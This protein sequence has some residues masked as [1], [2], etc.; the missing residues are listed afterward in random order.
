MHFAVHAVT[1][2][3]MQQ[4]LN[5]IKTKPNPLTEAAYNELLKPS[6]GNAPKF[7]VGVPSNFFQNVVDLYMNSSGA[8]HP[9]AN[10]ADYSK[11]E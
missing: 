1:A 3:Q 5:Q 11:K 10:Q 4:W 9:R 6:I 2:E 8:V 7:F